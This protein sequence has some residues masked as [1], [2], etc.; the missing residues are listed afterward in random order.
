MT[1]KFIELSATA[2]LWWMERE[3]NKEKHRLNEIVLAE[4]INQYLTND[5]LQMFN[6][7]DHIT[8][9]LKRLF[10]KMTNMKKTIMGSELLDNY[11]TDE[12]PTRVFIFTSLWFILQRFLYSVDLKAN[13]EWGVERM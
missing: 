4:E 7:S 6:L 12:I 9:V 1:S 5:I 13:N 8:Y 3:E 11:A 10:F 2:Q